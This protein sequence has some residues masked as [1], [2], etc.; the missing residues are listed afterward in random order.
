M[1]GFRGIGMMMIVMLLLTLILG[2]MGALTRGV[3]AGKIDPHLLAGTVIG[4][5]T[6]IILAVVI[7]VIRLFK[8]H[9]RH[10]REAS[11]ADILAEIMAMKDDNSKDKEDNENG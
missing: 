11:S 1:N 2:I 7:A 8:K 5:V 9:E 10:R 6:A 4:L 3:K